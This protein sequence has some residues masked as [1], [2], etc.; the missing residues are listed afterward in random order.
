MPLNFYEPI[1]DITA[2]AGIR[3]YGKT[4]DEVICNSVKALINEMVDLQ[5]VKPKEKLILEVE[6]IGFPYLIADLLNKILY[7]FD[8]KKFLP[9]ECKVLE[10]RENGSFVRLLLKGEKYNPDKHGKRL[11]IK[12]ATYHRLKMDKKGDLYKVEVIFDI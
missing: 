8:V 12:A 2:D 10:L 6:S 9:R 7:L 3:V 4:L 5:K 1:Y 11:L